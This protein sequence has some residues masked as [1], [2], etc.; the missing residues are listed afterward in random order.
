MRL[1]DQQMIFSFDI[2]INGKSPSNT[3]K[4]RE[5]SLKYIKKRK[6]N[7]PFDRSFI[8]ELKDTHTGISPNGSEPFTVHRHSHRSIEND[9]KFFQ[10]A[11]QFND[12]LTERT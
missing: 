2:L 6:R 9:H 12:V 11:E 4:K 10:N 5:F 3:R 1:I 7:R 8:L